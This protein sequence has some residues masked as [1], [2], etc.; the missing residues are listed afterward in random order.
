MLIALVVLVSA[1][2]GEARAADRTEVQQALKHSTDV[3]RFFDNHRWMLASRHDKCTG[4]PWQ[5]TCSIA[6]LLYR[7]HR[8][9]AE[10]YRQTLW[11]SLPKTGDWRTAVKL[12]QRAYPGTEDWL[13]FISHREGGYGGFVMNHQGSGAGGWM[14]FMSST[15][16]AYV[17]DARAN[18]HSRGF[19]VSPDVWSW[20]NP[21][22]QALTAGYMRYTGRDGC[23]WCL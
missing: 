14:Q 17:D 15:F 23:H 3:V 9:E 2:A 20:T 19:V 16:Y 21:M 22:G 5:R 6:R 12:A 8:A 18:F 1:S 4:V 11:L 13:L 10:R 7:G